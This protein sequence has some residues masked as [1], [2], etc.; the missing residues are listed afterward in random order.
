MTNDPTDTFERRRREWN[1][2]G[3]R[4]ATLTAV[5]LLA[6]SAIVEERIG[7]PSGIE[8]NLIRISCL[9]LLWIGWLLTS[10]RR[11]LAVAYIDWMMPAVF[12]W[13]SFFAVRL[14]LLHDGYESPYFLSLAFC[15]VG[16]PAVTLWPVRLFLAYEGVISALY[17][18]PLAL[19]LASI[20]SGD[21]FLVRLY[22]LLGLTVIAA[23]TQW[24]HNRMIRLE[25][26]AQ[27]SLGA[28]L[29]RIAGMKSERLAW[30]ES[31]AGFLQHELKNQMVAVDTSLGLMEQTDPAAKRD[32]YVVR[33][34]RSL[35]RMSRLVGSATEATSL[36]SALASEV[37]GPVDLSI[38]VEDRLLSLRHALAPRALATKIDAGVTVSGN[39]DRLAQMVDKLLSNAAEHVADD[40]QVRVELRRDG[41]EA[42]LT[43]EDDG[44]PLPVDK[45]RLFDAFVSVDKKRPGSRNLGLGLFVTKVIATSFDGRVQAEDL[46]NQ[47]GARFVVRLPLQVS[48]AQPIDPG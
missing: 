44:D 21:V 31:L 28:A 26:A 19:G 17:L 34:R 6:L 47:S 32:R 25:V 15:V 42:V 12:V 35:G 45:A 40:G 33:A 24:M 37:R 3:F 7:I 30:L 36:E 10:R 18:G 9:G 14:M 38:V 16:V 8:R 11:E 41:H 5:P 1:V 22:F 2:E 43:V 39:E 4:T 27:A 48:P 46:P 29:G 20:H 13:L 23:A